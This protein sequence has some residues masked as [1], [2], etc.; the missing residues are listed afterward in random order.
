MK[1]YLVLPGNHKDTTP[2]S[3][4][5][6]KTNEDFNKKPPHSGDKE[7][8]INSGAAKGE[9]NKDLLEDEDDTKNPDA[10]EI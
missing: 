7:L 9:E 3:S 4:A 1:N 8:K 6:P 5:S 2:P 10:R